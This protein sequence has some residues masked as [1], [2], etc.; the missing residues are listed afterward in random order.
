MGTRPR[1]WAEAVFQVTEKQV[2][3]SFLSE[4]ACLGPGMCSQTQETADFGLLRDRAPGSPSGS[5]ACRE[6]PGPAAGLSATL[7]LGGLGSRGEQRHQESPRTRR[8]GPGLR[9]AQT[10]T[11]WR[12]HVR[13]GD[14]EQGPGTESRPGVCTQLVL[15][16]RKPWGRTLQ[17]LLVT[18]RSRP[19]EGHLQCGRV[20]GL[21]TWPSA[22]LWGPEYSVCPHT[23]FLHWPP[24][25]RCLCRRRWQRGGKPVSVPAACC[26]SELRG[27]GTRA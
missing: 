26:Q 13:E 8:T 2:I 10:W 15:V 12:E 5:Q 7:G 11:S 16:G 9:M 21:R 19:C 24:P 22:W 3:S 20:T 18:C 23:S 17:V 25:G 14:S 27:V 1:G 6:S 4:N